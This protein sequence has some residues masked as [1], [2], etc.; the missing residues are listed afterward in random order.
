V[1]VYDRYQESDGDRDK[2]REEQVEPTPKPDDLKQFALVVVR[3]KKSLNDDV[4]Y[5]ITMQDD[6]FWAWANSTLGDV[7][8]LED[9]DDL[10]KKLLLTI[11]DK[12]PVVALVNM[13]T[14]KVQWSMP[15][16]KGTTDPIRSKLK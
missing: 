14:R 3:D 1:T 10:A 9:D 7:E 13:Q 2:D 11:A 4:Q 12:P 16:P 15:L 6:E 5:T 8:V